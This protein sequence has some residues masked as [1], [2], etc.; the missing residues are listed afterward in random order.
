MTKRVRSERRPLDVRPTTD[1]LENGSRYEEVGQ[2]MSQ[3]AWGLAERPWIPWLLSARNSALRGN[4][5]EVSAAD[6]NGGIATDASSAECE[7]D[8]DSEFAASEN[9]NPST[10]DDDAYLNALYIAMA[11]SASSSGEQTRSPASSS[12][13]NADLNHSCDL[14][15][16]ALRLLWQNQ[17]QELRYRRAT[18]IR[19]Q[20]QARPPEHN[21]TQ[22]AERRESR[23][24]EVEADDRLSQIMSDLRKLGT[25]LR[26]D[27]R[28]Q[29]DVISDD[30][31]ALPL[32]L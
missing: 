23:Q 13:P 31:A 19:N 4:E 20:G 17:I 32:C 29:L 22:Q 25:Q 6:N 24:A 7:S 8:P 11:T 10:Y 5:T 9:Q 28:K 14:E 30:I 27:A 16:L 3:M 1:A 2:E 15:A 18:Q 12:P 21:F 26:E